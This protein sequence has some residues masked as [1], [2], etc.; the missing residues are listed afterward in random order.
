MPLLF[1]SCPL[2]LP[3]HQSPTNLFPS[4]T[5]G[6]PAGSSGSLG[7]CHCHS[8]QT[9]RAAYLSS[10]HPIPARTPAAMPRLLSI[11]VRSGCLGVGYRP[12]YILNILGDFICSRVLETTVLA[13][14][15]G[16]STSC[17][18]APGCRSPSDLFFFFFF[19]QIYFLDSWVP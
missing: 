9:P 10:M 2:A 15:N 8:Y 13:S 14:I 16:I 17:P 1:H 5:L 6:Q 11:P 3:S 18:R 7:P 4:A 19:L 12:W